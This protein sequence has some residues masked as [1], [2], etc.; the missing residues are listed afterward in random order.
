M[1]VANKSDVVPV[2]HYPFTSRNYPALENKIPIDHTKRKYCTEKY[3][4]F[5]FR[6]R[7][8]KMRENVKHVYELKK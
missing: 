5:K 7:F 2:A 6:A 4:E 8:E 3:N 1:W